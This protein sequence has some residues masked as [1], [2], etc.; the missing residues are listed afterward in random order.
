MA[1]AMLTLLHR[2]G[3]DDLQS[4]GDSA[5]EFSLSDPSANVTTSASHG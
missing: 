4:F 3:M 1:D 2:L 5:G